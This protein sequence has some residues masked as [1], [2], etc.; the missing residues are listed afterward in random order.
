MANLPPGDDYIHHFEPSPEE[1]DSLV[2]DLRSFEFRLSHQSLNN[3]ASVRVFA[4]LDKYISRKP[5]KDQ[6]VLYIGTHIP[7]S[8]L[9]PQ[10]L[11]SIPMSWLDHAPGGHY[12]MKLIGCS[13]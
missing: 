1:I 6:W 2:S 10:C 7:F 5:S 9:L 3:P 11:N 12:R 4:F 8:L 13:L